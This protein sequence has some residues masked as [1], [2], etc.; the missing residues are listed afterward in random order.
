MGVSD[1]NNNE[2][3]L[4]LLLKLE[5]KVIISFPLFLMS[6]SKDFSVCG[7]I[8]DCYFNNKD[9]IWSMVYEITNSIEYYNSPKRKASTANYICNK[10]KKK[11]I[12]IIQ[13]LLINCQ[14]KKQPMIS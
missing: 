3:F 9:F 5:F 8:Y 14:L 4:Q 2:L 1:S 7:D 12:L 10:K 13:L 6:K 11:K